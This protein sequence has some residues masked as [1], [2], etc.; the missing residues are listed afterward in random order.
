[1]KNLGGE[2]SMAK[3]RHGKLAQKEKWERVGRLLKQARMGRDLSHAKAAK[4]LVRLMQNEK[5]NRAFIWKCEAG[6]RAVDVLE[7]VAFCEVYQLDP[8][9]VIRTIQRALDKG[10]WNPSR[11]VSE[12][13]PHLR[14]R[15][16][17]PKTARRG[18][19]SARAKSRRGVADVATD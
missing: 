1:M 8:A 5:L 6:R 2:I 12:H 3:T 19:R 4:K 15:E 14:I 7:L 17:R 18:K 11:F 9:K 10:E 13:Q 16:I